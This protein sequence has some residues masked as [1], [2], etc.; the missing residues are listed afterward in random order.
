MVDLP[1]HWV[2]DR[3]G[4]QSDSCRRGGD[5]AVPL[6]L[7]AGPTGYNVLRAA[8]YR[9]RDGRSVISLVRRSIRIG[10]GTS[11]GE[12]IDTLN[13]ACTDRNAWSRRATARVKRLAMSFM[14]GRSRSDDEV[15]CASD[16][17]SNEAHHLE[18]KFR[19]NRTALVAIV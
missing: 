8:Q 18:L 10:I 13:N 6:G 12:R 9:R 16:W 4:L 5:A 15:E 2:D 11:R 3:V 14:A 1:V 19:E 17:T 7:P